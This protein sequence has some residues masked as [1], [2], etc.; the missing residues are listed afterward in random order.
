MAAR[1]CLVR[2]FGAAVLLGALLALPAPSSALWVMGPGRVLTTDRAAVVQRS[3]S[4]GSEIRAWLTA[5]TALIALLAA[6]LAAFQYIRDQ[7]LNARVRFEQQFAEHLGV[8]ADYSTGGNL[9]SANV[10]WSL[11]NLRE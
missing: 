2:A 5:S 6:G 8:L 7:R 9:A 11:E 3:A 1:A 10:V 4:L